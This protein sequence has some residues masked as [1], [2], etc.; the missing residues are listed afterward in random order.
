M[1]WILLFCAIGLEVSGQTFLKM[2]QGWS[3]IVPL[4]TAM[5][6]FGTSFLIYSFAIKNINLSLA[7]PIWSGLG[8][9]AIAVVGLLVFREHISPLRWL[10][11]F[12][13]VAGIAGLFLSK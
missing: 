8:C 3:R 5:V 9:A 13:I 4:L 11:I 6:F 10:F 7:Y 12:V 1:H 2:A